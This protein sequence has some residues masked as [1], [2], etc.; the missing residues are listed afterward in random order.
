M[1]S[2]PPEL[3]VLLEGSAFRL[4]IYP[5]RTIPCVHPEVICEGPVLNSIVP[6]LLNSVLMFNRECL[7]TGSLLVAKTHGHRLASM[8]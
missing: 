6:L 2:H 4:R 7:S 1:P 5:V 3:C 8:K